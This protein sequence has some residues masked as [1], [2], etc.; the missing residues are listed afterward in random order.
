VAAVHTGLGT[1]A[2]LSDAGNMD[3]SGRTPPPQ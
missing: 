1:A 3:L 2:L